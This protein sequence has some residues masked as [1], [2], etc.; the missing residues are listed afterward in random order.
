[1]FLGKGEMGIFHKK[2]NGSF[3]EVKLR[4]WDR[5]TDFLSNTNT[6]ALFFT[7]TDKNIF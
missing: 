7:P 6:N 2:R 3:Q 4:K 5:Q 1:M